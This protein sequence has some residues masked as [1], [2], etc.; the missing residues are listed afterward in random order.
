MPSTD[1]PVADGDLLRGLADGE[2]DAVARLFERYG[3]KM[4]AFARRYVGG[5]ADADDVVDDLMQRWLEQ[6]PRPRDSGRLISFLAVSVYHASIDWIRRE[7]AAQGQVP[8]PAG[9]AATAS[10]T[11]S[12]VPASTGGASRQAL[13]SRLAAAL[14]RIS[15]SDR[16]L[17]ESHYGHALTSGE[18]M[19]LLGISRD[20]FHQRLHRARARLLS[21]LETP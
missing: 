4:V 12:A 3:S 10:P 16:L 7:R 2:P 20:A 21:L 13:E 17:L 9:S 14:E 1:V 15:S 19:A 6:P 8:R 18:C 5:E 11:G